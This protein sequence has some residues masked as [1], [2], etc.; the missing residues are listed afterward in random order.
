MSA[1]EMADRAHE[2]I[3]AAARIAQGK[4]I[5]SGEK[6]KVKLER[7]SLGRF[8]GQ[9][10]GVDRNCGRTEILKIERESGRISCYTRLITMIITKF[11]ALISYP[12]GYHSHKSHEAISVS[13]SGFFSRDGCASN[14]PR[15]AC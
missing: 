12:I 13:G 5:A 6:Y 3:F 9:S 11:L 7:D 14:L 8:K 1:N 4:R 15:A 10:Q 2:R